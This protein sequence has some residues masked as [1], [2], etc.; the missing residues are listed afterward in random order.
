VSRPL[1]LL[2][3]F[4]ALALIVVVGGLALRLTAVPGDSSYPAWGP[5]SQCCQSR[6]GSSSREQALLTHFTANLFLAHDA[7]HCA[8]LASGLES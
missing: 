4:G 8:V 5:R 6:V 2:I 7:D 1:R 3:I